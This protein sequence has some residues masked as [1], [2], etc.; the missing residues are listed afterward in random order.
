MGLRGY[1]RRLPD[2]DLHR[3]ADPMIFWDYFAAEAPAGF[4]PISDFDVDKAWHGLHFLLTGTARAGDFP[5]NF[6]VAGGTP[7]GSICT[8]CDRPRTFNADE[9]RAIADALAEIEPAALRARFDPKAMIRLGIY[10][11]IIWDRPPEE[12][13][14]LGYLMYFYEP[15]REFIACGA[16]RGEALLAF[17]G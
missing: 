6:I 4:G 10:P 15:L 5:L 11:S 2:A 8:C 14:T 13:D 1:F 12:D 3:L 16:R 7:V 17:I 9:V